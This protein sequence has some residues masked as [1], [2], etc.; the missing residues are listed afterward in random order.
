MR[1]RARMIG[2]LTLLVS[3]CL[4]AFAGSGSAADKKKI[5]AE[6]DKIADLLDKGK[7]DDAKKA[8]EAFA[9]GKDF[10]LGETMAIFKLR[11]KGGVGLGAKTGE[12]KPD[13]IEAMFISLEKAQKK[14]VDTYANELGHAAN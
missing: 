5:A 8:A 12:I 1:M 2:T 4:L 7:Q 6:L 13:G 3:I 10:D 11:T 9:K 14:N